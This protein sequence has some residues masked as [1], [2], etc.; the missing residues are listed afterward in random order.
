MI[1]LGWIIYLATKPQYKQVHNFDECA[2]ADYSVTNDDPQ[3]CTDPKGHKFTHISSAV[4]APATQTALAF[5][6]L[7]LS[8]DGPIKP[9]RTVITNQTDW[10][11]FWQRTHAHLSF[12]PTLIPVDFS[13]KAVIAVVDGQR[14]TPGFYTKIVEVDRQ[15]DIVLVTIRQDV[16]PTSCVVPGAPVSPYHL[17]QVDKLDLPVRFTINTTTLA[18]NCSK[19]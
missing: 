2:R 18:A 10:Q 3:V 6:T 8:T 5:D 15:S 1:G 9:E 16:P 12:R 7:V 14:P 17:I 19:K 11:A 13:K 4:A